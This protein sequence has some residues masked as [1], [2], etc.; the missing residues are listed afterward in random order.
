VPPHNSAHLKKMEI[1]GRMKE[2]RLTGLIELEPTRAGYV[3]DAKTGDAVR[4][5]P[6]GPAVGTKP[7]TNSGVG[8]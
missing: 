4:S 3:P 6:F 2:A 5:F 1:Q 8:V 7:L